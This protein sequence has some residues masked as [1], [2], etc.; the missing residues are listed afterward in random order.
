MELGLRPT[1]WVSDLTW[2]KRG[3]NFSVEIPAEGVKDDECVF[4]L[5]RISGKTARAVTAIVPHDADLSSQDFYV[6]TLMPALAQFK[7]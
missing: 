5:V 1:A 3:H 4:A 2:S 6:R 7:K